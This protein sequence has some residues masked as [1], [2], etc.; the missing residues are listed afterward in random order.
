MSKILTMTTTLAIVLAAL[1]ASF[2]QS[3]PTGVLA[4]FKAYDAAFNARDAVH[5]LGDSAHPMSVMGTVVKIEATRIQVKTGN[6]K[7][8][9]G[10][11]WY[12][13]DEK[14]TFKRGDKIVKMAEAKIKPDERVVLMLDH[15]EEGPMKTIEIRL[16][17]R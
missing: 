4:F 10:P 15:A 14:T 2:A 7:P 1:T 3:D 16:Q 11:T 17:A 6:E 8:G 5:M 9:T 12:S 13:I